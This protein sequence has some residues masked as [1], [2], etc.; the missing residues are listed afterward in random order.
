MWVLRLVPANA[1]AGELRRGAF[2]HYCS[3]RDIY[4]LMMS[5]SVNVL[6]LMSKPHAFFLGDL[7]LAKSTHAHL[8][9]PHA[10]GLGHD[11]RRWRE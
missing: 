11:T 9:P 10:L 5:F 3:Y 6:R 2:S 7:F 8:E 4:A 1:K